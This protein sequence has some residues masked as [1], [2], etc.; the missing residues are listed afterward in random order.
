MGEVTHQ[1]RGMTPEMLAQV[2]G[3]SSRR[4]YAWPVLVRK[5]M[6]TLW[7]TR[8]PMAAMF[9]WQSNVNYRNVSFG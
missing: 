8:N 2:M 3:E 6:R 5:A 4:M 9:A 1:P 7:E